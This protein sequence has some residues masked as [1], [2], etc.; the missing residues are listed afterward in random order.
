M[1]Y[2]QNSA[3]LR[4]MFP[5]KL[6]KEYYVSPTYQHV[7][8]MSIEDFLSSPSVSPLFLNSRLQDS[9]YNSLAFTAIEARPLS[10]EDYS[11]ESDDKYDAEFLSAPTT[12]T[13]C[14]SALASTGEYNSDWRLATGALLSTDFSATTNQLLNNDFLQLS[15]FPLAFP[16]TPPMNPKLD[17]LDLRAKTHLHPKAT[18]THHSSNLT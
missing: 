9:I 17:L 12:L 14:F 15:T 3:L 8:S 4:E 13:N 6:D 16:L 2:R 7:A 5:D 1:P 10:R 18:L 11:A